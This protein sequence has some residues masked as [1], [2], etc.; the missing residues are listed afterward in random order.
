M[1]QPLNR[2]AP[3]QP[4]AAPNK[5]GPCL[6]KGTMGPPQLNSTPPR[7][8]PALL[9]PQ[10]FLVCSF[11]GGHSCIKGSFPQSPPGPPRPD[12]CISG[13]QIL[14][15]AWEF[16]GQCFQEGAYCACLLCNRGACGFTQQRVHRA[17]QGNSPGT[18][19][20]SKSNTPIW[21]ICIFPDWET[22]PSFHFLPPQLLQQK[23]DSVS[24][25]SHHT[26]RFDLLFPC[27]SQ[28]ITLT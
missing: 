24:Q 3:H 2:L 26:R 11:S 23:S 21:L 17:G 28:C 19:G 16:N 14:P 8:P 20:V 15:L 7:Q 27:N 22:V 25:S 1:T 5:Y 10:N 9:Q 6:F 18:A 12:V 13:E 4:P